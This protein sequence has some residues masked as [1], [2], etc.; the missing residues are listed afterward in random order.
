MAYAWEEEAY[1]K[2]VGIYTQVEGE[3]YTQVGCRS[4]PVEVKAYTQL[5]GS[6]DPLWRQLM[7]L[8]LIRIPI[9]QCM[10]T[11]HVLFD[12]SNSGPHFSREV[13]NH[14]SKVGRFDGSG[15]SVGLSIG[16]CS[17]TAG[18]HGFG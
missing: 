18:G 12:F 8:K 9:Y 15:L 3:S 17:T 2:V 5:L 16:L 10:I 11:L 4:I 6:Y 13:L 14:S 1:T 7:M